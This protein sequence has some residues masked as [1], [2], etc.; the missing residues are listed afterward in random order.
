[1]PF[2]RMS[3]TNKIQAHFMHTL[4]NTTRTRSSMAAEVKVPMA[5]LVPVWDTNAFQLHA[6]V[7]KSLYL[8]CS[9]L[10]STKD[11]VSPPCRRGR[12]LPELR[13]SAT[14]VC[15][16]TYRRVD[17]KRWPQSRQC[18]VNGP[19]AVRRGLVH[20]EKCTQLYPCASPLRKVS[21]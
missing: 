2:P 6:V 5:S 20:D 11:P 10:S 17:K 15:R 14:R 16:P 13:P 19:N 3:S 8:T 7:T 21:I 18:H 1:M 4:Q 9:I 12:P